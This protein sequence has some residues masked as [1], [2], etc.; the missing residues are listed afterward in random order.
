[1]IDI[2][3]Q[4]IGDIRR[5]QQAGIAKYGTT[6][7]DSPLG[8]QAWLQHTYEELLDAAIYAKRVMQAA[9]SNA[10]ART[11]LCAI[12]CMSR[13]SQFMADEIERSDGCNQPFIQGMTTLANLVNELIGDIIRPTENKTGETE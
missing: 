11:D 10:T 8:Q 5:R 13:I 9:D 4:V 12:A 3:S 2:E 1:M 7:A 6:V